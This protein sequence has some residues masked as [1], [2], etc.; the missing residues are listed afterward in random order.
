M[1][2]AQDLFYYRNL[3]EEISLEHIHKYSTWVHDHVHIHK[4]MALCI[5]TEK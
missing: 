3:G 4:S 1:L 2:G 5:Q